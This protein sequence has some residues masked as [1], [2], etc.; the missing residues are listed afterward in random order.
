MLEV[1]ELAASISISVGFALIGALLAGDALTDWF[2]DLQ[3]PRYAL[4]LWGWVIVGGLY[5]I[6]TTALLYRAFTRQP[7]KEKPPLLFMTIVMMVGNEAWNYLL[8]GLESTLAGFLGLIAFATY[9]AFLFTRSFRMDRV[10]AIILS[11]YVVWLGY[12]LWWMYT[13]WDL[14]S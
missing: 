9:V 13:L 8:F 12:D 11:P 3:Q 14:N 10:S 1:K 5:Y 2:Q 4:P 7:S 6:M